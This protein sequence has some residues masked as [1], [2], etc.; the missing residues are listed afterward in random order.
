MMIYNMVYYDVTRRLLGL[1]VSDRVIPK[2]FNIRD[3]PTVV[4]HGCDSL[5]HLKTLKKGPFSESQLVAFGPEG[6]LVLQSS[7]V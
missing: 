7:E 4:I 2:M 1:P 3:N 5:L 6:L